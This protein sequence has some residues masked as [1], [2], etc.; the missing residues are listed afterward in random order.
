M[1]DQQAREGPE[2]QALDQRDG[3]GNGCR[4]R[5]KRLFEAADKATRNEECPAFDINGADHRR[6]ERPREDE[7]SG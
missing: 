4:S 6:E 1:S 3:G 5:A 2:Q 7:P